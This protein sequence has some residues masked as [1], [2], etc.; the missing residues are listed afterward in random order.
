[1]IRIDA[2]I[3]RFP[4]LEA[5]QI[6]DWVH[7]IEDWRLAD[8]C[9]EI[10]QVQAACRVAADKLAVAHQRSKRLFREGA[11]QF[12]EKLDP[13]VRV[14]VPRFWQQHPE[15]RNADSIPHDAQH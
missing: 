9:T 10:G 3:A 1:M 2:V 13:L 6:A 11:S 15:Q 7:T 8:G 14:R 12:L 4:G 5:P